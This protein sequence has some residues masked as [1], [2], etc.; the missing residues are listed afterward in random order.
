MS[1]PII[2]PSLEFF[3]KADVHPSKTI[4]KIFLCRGHRKAKRIAKNFLR[5][6]SQDRKFL[7]F[8]FVF[9]HVKRDTADHAEERQ[10][11]PAD[12]GEYDH[13]VTSAPG[14]PAHNAAPAG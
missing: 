8:V 10:H 7:L 12:G 14:R 3:L 6:V 1:S 5:L 2:F 11:D 9:L 4:T 13:S